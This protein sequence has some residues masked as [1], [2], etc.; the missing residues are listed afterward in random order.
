[1]AVIAT[2]TTALGRGE[3]TLC[4]LFQRHLW[5]LLDF[6]ASRCL[7]SSSEAEEQCLHVR[8]WVQPS[9]GSGAPCARPTTGTSQHSKGGTS[10]QP[11]PPFSKAKKAEAYENPKRKRWNEG[12]GNPR[13]QRDADGIGWRPFP[14]G[15]LQEQLS[16]METHALG[17]HRHGRWGSLHQEG[18]YHILLP[19][20]LSAVLFLLL[21]IL[22]WW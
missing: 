4:N 11:L 2:S 7:P 12:Y 1:M 18:F 22:T 6:C 9:P 5:T 8:G 3:F 17:D 13:Q 15:L 16:S 20:D 14:M 19:S 10:L 21:P